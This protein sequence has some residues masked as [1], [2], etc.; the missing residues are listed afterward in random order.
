MSKRFYKL[1]TITSDNGIMLDNR[2][3][4]T[5]QKAALSMPTRTLAEE[6]AAEWRSQGDKVL[7]LSMPL[8][9]LANTAV[10]RI[11]AERRKIVD[12]VVA[13]A[14]SDLVCYRA[15]EPQ[16]LVRRQDELWNPVV[17]W[18]LRALDAPFVMTTG[19]MHA[20]QPEAAL[21]AFEAHIGGMDDFAIAGLHTL[22][23][24][25]GSALL[26]AML[27]AQQ[28]DAE[29]AWRAAF[30]DED[31]QIEQWGEDDEASVMRARRRK[32]YDACCRYLAA[33]R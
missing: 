6:V 12:E 2:V 26:A 5:P 4:K 33:L 17:D 9:R 18:A 14:G 19:V 11:G 23:T 32:E 21:R 15:A 25:T 31:W 10:D 8:T 16:G 29:A 27:A 24:L 20:K 30:A 1:V 7:P 22:T 3:L 28:I 13:F